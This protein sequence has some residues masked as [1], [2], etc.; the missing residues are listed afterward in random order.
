MRFL[1]RMLGYSVSGN[2][3]VSPNGSGILGV[4]IRLGYVLENIWS[5]TG[6]IAE[7]VAQSESLLSSI[8]NRLLSEGTSAGTYLNQIASRVGPDGSL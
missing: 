1:Y 2:G 3:L 8:N 7:D 6:Q 5:D 4:M